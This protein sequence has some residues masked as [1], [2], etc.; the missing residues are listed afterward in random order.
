[1]SVQYRAVYWNKDK[2]RYDLLLAAGVLLYLAAFVGLGVVLHPN[3]TAET[4]LIRGLATLAFLM[5]HVIL[6]IGPLA[7]LNPRFLPL[8]YNRRHFGVTMFVVALAH[9]VF[10]IIQFHALGDINP[11][12]SIFVSNTRVDSLANFPFQALGFFAL[13]ILFLMAATSHD[14]W[15]NTLSPPVWKRLHMLVYLAYALLFAHVCLGALQSERGLAPAAVLVAGFATLAVLHVAAASKERVVDRDQPADGYIEVG[16]LAAIPENRARLVCAGGERIAVFRYD[17]KVSAVSNLCAHQNGPLGEGRI[18]DGCIT[19]PWHG[20]QYLPDSGTSPPPFTEKI[21]TY[22]T[23]V[24]GGKVF[25]DP[26][27]LPPGTF[28]E[29]ARTDA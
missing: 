8:L 11:I 13:L 18:I 19:C 16:A 15:L 29:P 1:M 21:A 17:G 7:R 23:K 5:L 22:R 3:A 10:S 9:S 14:F 28:V 24:A 27:P 26:K 2:K 12:V 4:L 6:A 20:Y 25:V